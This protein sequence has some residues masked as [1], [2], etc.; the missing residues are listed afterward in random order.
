MNYYKYISLILLPIAILS[1]LNACR[2]F[3]EAKPDAKMVV[4]STMKDLRALLDDVATMN[5]SWPI[6]GEV[7]ADNYYLQT[8]NWKS[9][10]SLT[11]RENYIWKEDVSNDM[12]W[13]LTY[14]VVLK[15][16]LILEKIAEIHPSPDQV[17]EWNEIK[18]SAM[19]YR[20][21]AFFMIAQEFAM[22]YDPQ[23]ATSESGIPIRLTADVNEPS[24]RS[25]LKDTYN[26]IIKD[27]EY[28]SQLLPINV[29]Y[30]TRPSRVAALA[31]L[32]RVHLTIGDYSKAANYADTCINAGIQLLD[33]NQL[34]SATDGAF[35]RFNNE[36]I[37]HIAANYSYSLDASICKVDSLLISAYTTGDLRKQLFYKINTDGSLAFSGNY[38]GSNS[39]QLYVGLAADEVYLT[40]AECQ[41]RTSRNTDALRTLNEFMKN[42]YD[43][44]SFTPITSTANLID[45]IL[46]ERRKELPFRA[47][48]WMDIRR[49]NTLAGG[50]ITL[51]RRIDNEIYT[52]P[53][54][55]LRYA[56]QIPTSVLATAQSMER[57]KR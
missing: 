25:S 57:N 34:S 42:R 5:L 21:F 40:L 19:F 10:S 36:V 22:P 24:Y 20:S 55:D 12:D 44:L 56:M 9:I 52:L 3:L 31:L 47:I 51:E 32:S 28:A 48:R 41:A 38:D 13:T 15:A 35:K 30:K 4:P 39:Y 7:A 6:A 43:K 53:P 11:D 33:Y 26:T 49:L 54:G 27:L 14:R 46:S 50:N 1:S 18:G 45:I 2:K 8:N 29:A 16:N 23:S 37:F 17:K